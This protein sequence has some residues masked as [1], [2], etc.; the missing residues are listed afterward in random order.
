MFGAVRTAFSTAILI[1]AAPSLAATAKFDCDTAAQRFSEVTLPVAGQHVRVSGAIASQ[2]IRKDDRWAP[3]LSLYL[4]NGERQW[5]GFSVIKLPDQPWAVTLRY[6]G[7]ESEP[8]ASLN[9][10]DPTPFTLDVNA[11][12]GTV[13]L[14]LGPNRYH[15]SGNSFA[16]QELTLSCSTGNFLFSQ[17]SWEVLPN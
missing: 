11:S 13:D 6:N 2:M 16:A 7:T 17:L 5:G 14:T 8:V 1:G 15:A 9:R 3:K 12:T 10:L 4:D